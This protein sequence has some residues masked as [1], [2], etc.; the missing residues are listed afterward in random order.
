MFGLW[1]MS[2]NMPFRDEPVDSHEQF[3]STIIVLI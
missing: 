3:N 2:E 1:T